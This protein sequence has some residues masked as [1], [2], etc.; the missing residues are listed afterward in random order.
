ML[1]SCFKGTNSDDNVYYQ[2][3]C[4]TELMEPFIKMSKNDYI[5]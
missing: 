1:F 4:F 2:L 3:K 5:K